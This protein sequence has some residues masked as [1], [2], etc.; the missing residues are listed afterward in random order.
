MLDLG[1]E[2]P[3]FALPD[4]DGRPF[5]LDGIAGSKPLLIVFLCN[6]CPYVKHMASSF[7]R[8]ARDYQ[9][10]GLAVAG[11]SS[12]DVAT[13]PADGPSQM[14]EFARANG[15]TFPYLYDESQQTALAYGAVCTP[16]LFLFDGKRRLVYR[17]QFD[18]S[19][20]N[21]RAPV[22]GADLRAAADAVLA[23]QPVDGT[24]VASA[25]CSIKWKPENEPDWA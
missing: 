3:K 8:F 6:H 4:G 17:G 18:S 13:Y 21:S 20:P 9:A 10:Q 12:N 5:T 11:I 22:T 14:V 23:G 1:T 16:D 2:A 25:G 24:Q 7:A 19:R 15:F